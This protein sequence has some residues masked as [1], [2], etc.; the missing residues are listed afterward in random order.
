MGFKNLLKMMDQKIRQDMDDYYVIDQNMMN[1]FTSVVE[2]GA[3]TIA[4]QAKI[5]AEQ[6]NE[7]KNLTMRL[8]E[9]EDAGN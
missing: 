5:I 1:Q 2:N 9:G 4:E 3:K 8:M 7:I 6:Q